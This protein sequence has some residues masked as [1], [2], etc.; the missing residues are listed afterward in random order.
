MPFWNT[1]KNECLTFGLHRVLLSLPRSAAPQAVW[2]NTPNCRL[3][4]FSSNLTSHQN[5]WTLRSPM[6]PFLSPRLPL[7]GIMELPEVGES[8][9]H[10]ADDRS[11]TSK[12]VGP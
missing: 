4:D 7:Q 1:N 3:R 11:W 5:E 2:A 9:W 6:L 10:T 12:G 8:R